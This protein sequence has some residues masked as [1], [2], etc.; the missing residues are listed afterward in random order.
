LASYTRLIEFK[1]K[2]TELNRAVNKLSKTLDRIDKSL[3]G[4]DKKLD[5]IAKQ[6]FGGI[7]K[8]AI[9]AEKSVG[10]LAKSV[11]SMSGPQGFTRMLT[12]AAL[13]GIIGKR[14]DIADAVVRLGALDAAIRVLTKGN[15]GFPA[16]SRK[17][18][19]ATTALTGFTL[20]HAGAITGVVG[21]SAAILTGTKFF[22]DLGKGV[23]QAEANMIDFIRTSRQLGVGKGLRSLFPK[24]SLWGGDERDT[25]SMPFAG[26]KAAAAVDK[27]LGR[28]FSGQTSPV[29]G[30]GAIGSLDTKRKALAQTQQVQEKLVALTGKHLQASI[31]VRKAM[32]GYN[33]ELAKTKA[34]Q[35]FVTADL[36]AMQ[37]AWQGIVSTMKGAGNLIGGIFGGK[38]GGAGKGLGVI[39]LSR[40][41]EILTGKLGFLNKAWI[42]NIN[43]IALWSAR[44]SEAITAVNVAY[45]IL[46]TGLN[47]ASWTAGAIKGFVDFEKQAVL[48]LNG[49]NAARRNLDKEMS[50]WLS[51]NK[52]GFGKKGGSIGPTQNK[53]G[54]L[55]TIFGPIGLMMGD[56][57]SDELQGIYGGESKFK[58][59]TPLMKRL[60]DNLANARQELS[61]LHS[62]SDKFRSQLVKVVQ[63]EERINKEIAKRK[64]L[65]KQISPTELAKAEAKEK[66][67]SIKR[68][69]KLRADADKKIKASALDRYKEIQ[70]RWELEA[71]NHRKEVQRINERNRLAKQRRADRGA[72]LGRFG[73]NV[74]LG[75][76]FPMLFGGGPG[77]VAGG[78]T[79]AVGQSLMGSKGFGMQIL[80]SALGQQV[81]AFVG[82]T[83]E[84]GKAFNALNPDVDAVIGALGETNTAY[85]KHLEMLKKIK[86]EA[87]AMAAAT[88]KLAQLIGQKG[89]NSFK[90]FG[91]DAQDFGNEMGKAFTLIRASVAELINNSGVLL[92]LT[93]KLSKSNRFSQFERRVSDIQASGKS[94]GDMNEN[95]KSIMNL[96][97]ERQLVEQNVGGSKWKQKVREMVVTGLIPKGMGREF[98]SRSPN[99]RK[100][101]TAVDNDIDALMKNINKGETGNLLGSGADKLY[102]LDKKKQDLERIIELGTVEAGIQQQI[103]EE[104]AAQGFTLETIDA[105][106]LEVIKKKVR[107]LEI[108]KE[109]AAEVVKLENIYKQIAQTIEDGLV[110]AIEGAID[111]T[112]TLGQ[113][114]S[115]VFR[116]IGRMMLQY[117]VNSLM[118]SLPG[119]MGEYFSKRA[120]GGPVTGDTPYIVGEKGPELFVPNSS[121]NIVPNH[122]MGGSMVVN[123]DASGS[124]AEGDDDRSRQLGELIGAAVQSEII[125]QQRPGGTL[126]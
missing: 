28:T 19:E 124:S 59:R 6:G 122:A 71:S 48:S 102:S 18:I 23:R 109:Q 104:V 16:L 115:S 10:K 22:Y 81:D 107:D 121:G 12:G 34:V 52:P 84:L 20:A 15:A 49:V 118:G 76:G 44:A 27:E 60:E 33:L 75:A 4:I 25:S 65:Y 24:G 29:T 93:Q 66:E 79:G 101:L 99:Q 64:E 116:Q 105:D 51:K 72:A 56:R 50:S 62:T 117:G 9:K 17:L 98:L 73:E 108:T 67:E 45:S 119:K 11:K 113:V 74:M 54:F 3:V 83:A 7:A 106:L 100:G 95:E 68:G 87:A 110:N 36:W 41:I 90:Q 61:K 37:K 1:V 85:G 13:G 77:A 30:Y 103:A 111:G 57:M 82:K 5:H 2:D 96:H 94:W 97:G 86:G 125:R 26:D 88:E 46:S 55:E 14:G 8:E 69:N 70:N 38:F 35:G 91:N 21:G 47:A 92:G 80:F 32:I 39:T 63:L 42:E 53:G 89:V 43:K 78:L 120:A 114:A 40:S 123:V 112:K 58:D 31:Q 126:Y